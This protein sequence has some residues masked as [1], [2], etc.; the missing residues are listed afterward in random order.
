V[1]LSWES[2]VTKEVIRGLSRKAPGSDDGHF[3][4]EFD[5]DMFF[6]KIKAGAVPHTKIVFLNCGVGAPHITR[7][8]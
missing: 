1:V 8:G 2:Y 7:T 3:A 4:A 6:C 5:Q